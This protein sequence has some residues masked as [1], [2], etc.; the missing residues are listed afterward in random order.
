MQKIYG[1]RGASAYAPEN[2]LEAFSLAAKMGAD[3]V[4]LDVHLCKSGE[5][6][7]AHDERIDR[8]ADGEGELRAYTLSELKQFHFNRTHPEYASARIPT[9]EEVFD[10]LAPTGLCVNVE[11]KT[12]YIDYPGL[13]EK[14]IDLAARKGMTDRVLYSSFNHLSVQKIKEIDP[15]LPCG[16]LYDL[17]P[18]EPVRYATNARMNA[19]HPHF[20]ALRV[21]GMV[22]EAHAAGLQVNPWT[23]NS[24]DDI[25]FCLNAGADII[26]SNYPD[27]AV[28]LR[29][30]ASGQ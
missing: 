19:L 14:C 17:V 4:E 7:V 26:I 29:N 28:S 11:I 30:A 25:R 23:V 6:V 1:H 5:I 9:L 20:S 10:L 18:I 8:V 15:S 12:G 16:L 13:E 21:P 27:R 24:E 3:G 22:A 2:T